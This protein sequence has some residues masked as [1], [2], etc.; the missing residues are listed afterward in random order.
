MIKK[1]E[2]LRK[3]SKELL[4]GNGAVFVGAGMSITAGFVNWKDLLRQIASDLE[5]DIDIEHDLIALAQYEVNRLKTRDSVDETIIRQFCKKAKETPCHQL[6]A[7]LP[8]D[9]VWTTNYDKVLEEAYT[10]AGRTT[11]V[12]ITT[13]QLRNR[14]PHADVSIFKMHGD[15]DSPSDAVL[16]KNDYECYESEKSAFTVQLLA[17]LLTK[18][19]LFLGFS[20]T[21]PNIEYT[22]NRLRRLLNPEKSKDNKMRDHYCILKRPTRE[23]YDKKQSDTDIDRLLKLDAK[24]F[25]HRV[26]DLQNYGIQTVAID[27]YQEVEEILRSLTQIVLTRTVM[28]SGAAETFEPMGEVKLNQF[29]RLLGQ[30]L[31]EEDFDIIS[32]VGKGISGDVMIGVH[33]ALTR[34][35][36]GRLGQRLRL[37]P[38]PYWMPDTPS[39]Q[40]YYEANRDEMTAQGGVA[41]V[42]CGNKADPNTG[43]I[44]DSPGVMTEVAKARKNG[45]FVIPIGATG[46]AANTIWKEAIADLPHYFP[47]LDV[48][49]E[50]NSLNDISKS[51]AALVN[52][53]LSIISKIRSN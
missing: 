53:I 19:F 18:R 13:D 27:K 32:G 24:R 11:D 28:I 33:E 25:E 10:K 34:P 3:Y 21:D 22:F 5:L 8:I 15:V 20:F 49:K 40:E 52:S 38:F 46:H 30:K 9:T 37:F 48:E 36:Q 1:N 41:I 47:S 4:D 29:C 23:D 50:M 35:K 6:L 39:R 16:T 12:K 43:K 2:F 51:P 7:R 26:I 44:I 42:I 17:D 45:Q 31:I 14:K